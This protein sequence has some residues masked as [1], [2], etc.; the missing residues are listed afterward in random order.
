M[1]TIFFK[2]EFLEDIRDGKKTQTI[3]KKN[4]YTTGDIC[5]INFKKDITLKILNV[6]KK[7]LL[8]ITN[9]DAQKDGFLNK[10]ALMDKLIEIYGELDDSLQLYLISF[11]VV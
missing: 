4:M 10:E 8:E 6:K 2:K 7:T 1:K 11:K 9:D 3:R 5:S